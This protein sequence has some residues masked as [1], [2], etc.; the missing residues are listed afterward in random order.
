MIVEEKHGARGIVHSV[1]ASGWFLDLC[2]LSQE[3]SATVGGLGDWCTIALSVNRWSLNC[4]VALH[5]LRQGI[6]QFGALPFSTRLRALCRRICTPA[7]IA[8][9]SSRKQVLTKGIAQEKAPAC[10]AS[11]Y[12]PRFGVLRR[13][14]SK[15][16]PPSLRFGRLRHRPF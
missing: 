16:R 15:E 14:S 1:G 12:T 11:S 4:P 6:R 10:G 13:L 8:P 7:R 2:Q 3:C 5:V 9:F